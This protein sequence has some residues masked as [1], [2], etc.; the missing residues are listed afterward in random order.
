MDTPFTAELNELLE[1]QE[2]SPSP[3]QMGEVRLPSDPAVLRQT[4]R[5]RMPKPGPPS[6]KDAP[7]PGSKRAHDRE[8][9]SV[10]CTMKVL[11]PD[12]RKGRKGGARKDKDQGGGGGGSSGGGGGTE[13]LAAQR[14][15]EFQQVPRSFLSIS[16]CRTVGG[17][18]LFG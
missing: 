13:A 10:I 18:V 12:S 5:P 16:V 14:E 2:A 8:L 17:G 15:A 7:P 6:D 3:N 9:D 11:S 1:R 4:P